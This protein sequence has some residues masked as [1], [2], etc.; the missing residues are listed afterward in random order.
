MGT[1]TETI[2]NPLSDNI[3]ASRHKGNQK[4]HHR[5]VVSDLD[6]YE[7]DTEDKGNQ[8]IDKETVGVSAFPWAG[9]GKKTESEKEGREEVE[10]QDLV[11]IG[12]SEGVILV[13]VYKFLQVFLS[14]V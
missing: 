10:D 1:V 9:A 5:D 12:R 13:N 2:V 3:G 4:R 11:G 14:K 6:K 8:P 7:G